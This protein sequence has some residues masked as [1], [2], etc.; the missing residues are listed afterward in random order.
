LQKMQEKRN[1]GRMKSWS[2]INL[3]SWHSLACYR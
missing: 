1:W 2:A 3:N